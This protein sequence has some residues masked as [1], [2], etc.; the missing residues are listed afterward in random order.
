MGLGVNYVCV[1][2]Y[3]IKHPHVQEIVLLIYG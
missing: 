2:A 3:I 1:Y